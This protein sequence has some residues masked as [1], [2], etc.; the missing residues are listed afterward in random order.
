MLGVDPDPEPRSLLAAPV[1]P[2]G[3]EDLRLEGIPAFGES[4]SSGA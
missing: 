4:V 2:E 3:V 1:L